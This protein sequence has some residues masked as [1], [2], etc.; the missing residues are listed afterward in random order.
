MKKMT[1]LLN[2]AL[3]AVSTQFVFADVSN[4]GTK[5]HYV[6]FEDAQAALPDKGYYER[7][8]GGS[9]D[10]SAPDWEDNPAGYE[11]TAT[12]SGAVVLND[13]VQMGDDGDIFAAFDDDGNT[14]GIALMLTPPFGPYAGTPVFEM[15]IR[16]NAAGDNITFKYYD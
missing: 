1:Y 5:E 12:I 4:K 6:S 7:P 13:G 8:E 16:S 15:Q 10:R 14:R 3:L 2:L 11:F 9:A